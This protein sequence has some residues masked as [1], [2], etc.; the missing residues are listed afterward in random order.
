MTLVG[1]LALT[2]LAGTPL[3]LAVAG[4]LVVQ[5]SGMINISLETMMLAA[6]LAGAAAASLTGSAAS[7]FV[8]GIAAAVMVAAIF[9]LL[10]INFDVDQ[11]VA[12][13]ALNLLVLGAT[14]VAYQRAHNLF[15][16]EIPTLHSFSWGHGIPV[17]ERL[18]WIVALAWLGAPG[19]AGFVIWRTRL[20]LRIRATGE[21]PETIVS[22]GLSASGYRWTA[23]A[24]ESVFAGIAGA[25]LSLALSPGFAENMVAG[26][27][28][29]ALAI[30]IFGRWNVRGVVAGVLLFSVGSSLQFAL[31]AQKQGLSFHLLLALPYVLTLVILVLSRAG[32]NAPAAL[33]RNLEG[34]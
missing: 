2:L 30:V 6:A 33:G 9:G 7:G 3:L 29:I 32:V 26:R 20:G 28:F 15:A 10:V 21:N 16:G 11:I 14:G 22:A 23:L 5:K 13:T 8:A 4:E 34:S 25:Y 27:G 19:I 12:G 18:D 17:L 1:I 31:Q 24:I